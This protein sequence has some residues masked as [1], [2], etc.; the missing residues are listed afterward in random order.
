MS[1][2]PMGFLA[3]ALVALAAPAAR[4]DDY[5]IGATSGARWMRSD[6]VD[7]LSAQD[8]HPV[9]GLEAS[10]RVPGVE[11]LGFELRAGLEYQLGGL[12]G[13]TFRRIDSS[14][15]SHTVHAV[16]RL[17]R[18]LSPRLSVYGRAALGY[19]TASLSVVDRMSAA[20]RPTRDRARAASGVLGV[21]LYMPLRDV[22]ILGRF[23]LRVELDYARVGGL[24]FR[25]EPDSGGDGALTI[26]VLAA[27]LG[28]LDISGLDFRVGLVGRF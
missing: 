2:V 13:T 12:T 25:A 21:G 16:G 4:A 5:E 24:A 20:T 6:S 27:S 15:L 22:P 11:L 28:E 7:T 23:G 10:R 8:A 9:V 1:K 17:E 26:P 18:R 14:L 19:T 3:A